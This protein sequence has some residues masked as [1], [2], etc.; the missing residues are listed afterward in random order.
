[1]D[2]RHPARLQFRLDLNWISFSL[3]LSF[4]TFT[5]GDGIFISWKASK[6]CLLGALY[7]YINNNCIYIR[8]IR[9]RI[10]TIEN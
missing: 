6:F 9:A 2:E 8:R 5:N 1:M 10:A 4:I 3:F 7:L